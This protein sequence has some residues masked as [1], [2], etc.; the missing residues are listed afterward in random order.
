MSKNYYESRVDKIEY[1][2]KDTLM[3]QKGGRKMRICTLVCISLTL[4]FSSCTMAP[5]VANH[6]FTTQQKMESVA[7]WEW[8][9]R[10]VVEFQVIPSLPSDP[11]LSRVYVDNSDTTDFGKAFYNYLVTELVN[12]GVVESR[13]PENAITVKWGTQLVRNLKDPW[14]PGVF[15]GSVETV[16]FLVAGSSASCPPNDYELI[17]TTQVN[18]DYMMLSRMS[19][20]F[21]IDNSSKWNFYEPKNGERF[22]R[23]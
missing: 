2:S 1:L 3:Y 10:Y 5:R 7:H 6:T 13:T 23:R 15:A 4:L 18:M 16:A 21:Y 8:L 20:N 17:V 22:A 9:A 12:H 14:W 11:E 19:H